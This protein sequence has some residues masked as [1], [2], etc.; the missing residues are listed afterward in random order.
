M[1]G[2][3][4][5]KLKPCIAIFC[6][7]PSLDPMLFVLPV[8]IRVKLR[9]KIN[10]QLPEIENSTVNSNH[11]VSLVQFNLFRL[12]LSKL[13]DIWL[14]LYVQATLSEIFIKMYF[15]LLLH[16]L[17]YEGVLT[18]NSMHLVLF[19]RNDSKLNGLILVLF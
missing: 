13:Y 1:L 5:K 11:Y 10:C 18:K 17:N 14:I 16:K 15:T 8:F 6:C 2:R 4:R 3:R 19:T 12:E 9:Y 7:C